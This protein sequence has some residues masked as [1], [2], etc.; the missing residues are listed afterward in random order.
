VSRVSL[1]T[2]FE[3]YDSRERYSSAR[4]DRSRRKIITLLFSGKNEK[5][6]TQNKKKPLIFR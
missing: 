3:G 6:T 5:T 1:Q 2:Q 4:S